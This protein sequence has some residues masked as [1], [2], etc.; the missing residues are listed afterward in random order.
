MEQKINFFLKVSII[1][2]YSLFQSSCETERAQ[3]LEAGSPSAMAIDDI[4]SVPSKKKKK[5][6]KNKKDK[7]R[8]HHH[9]KQRSNTPL[10]PIASN[11]SDA[12]HSPSSP[13]NDPDE[14]ALSES[15]LE[16]KRA[17]LLAQLNEQMEE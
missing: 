6:K 8:R 11:H 1:L 14:H 17:A 16:S 13:R 4:C 2:I 9:D 7:E 10:S 5:D 3:S 15:E 12:G